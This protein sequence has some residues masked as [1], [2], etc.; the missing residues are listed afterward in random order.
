M[1]T[2]LVDLTGRRAR[3]QWLANGEQT[4]GLTVWTPH[5]P[6]PERLSDALARARR[7]AAGKVDVI[8]LDVDAPY[9]QRA[10]G[11]TA[12]IDYTLIFIE[13]S[14][15]GMREADQ[16]AARL[17]DAPPA[18]GSIAA[19]FSRV[20]AASVEDLPQRTH[21]RGL[22]VLGEAPADYLLATGDEYS[23]TSGEPR[24]PHDT[25]L[26]AI[27][28]L[29]RA[30]IQIAGVTSTGYAPPPAGQPEERASR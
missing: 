14:E 7:Q 20:S 2:L 28:R 11:A 22:P 24:L 5:I 15:M 19:V 21:E 13:H 27:R 4:P 12:G 3:L 9:L 16:L 26:G 30:L 23:L 6:A 8:L 29:A 18:R 17:D 10:G 1:R 25:Y